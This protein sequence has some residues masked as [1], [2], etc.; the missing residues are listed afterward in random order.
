MVHGWITQH[1]GRYGYIMNP[2]LNLITLM[3]IGNIPIMAGHGN[4]IMIGVG[5]PSITEGGNMTLITAGCGYRVT[6]GHLPGLAGAVMMIIMDG[7][8]LDMDLT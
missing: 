6:S 8:R 3:A 2:I 4:L 5:L 1:M 7:H